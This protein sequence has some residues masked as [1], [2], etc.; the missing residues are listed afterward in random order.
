MQARVSPFP[1]RLPPTLRASLQQA[2]T[3]AKRSLAAEILLRLEKSEQQ[4][5]RQQSTI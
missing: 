4:Q 2:A 5:E 3:E 1:V